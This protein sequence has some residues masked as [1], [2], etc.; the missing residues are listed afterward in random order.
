MRS[1]AAFGGSIVTTIAFYAD[2]GYA[3]LSV[4]HKPT[5]RIRGR[6]LS[7]GGPV[8]ARHQD[9]GWYIG[10]QPITRITCQGAFGLEIEAGGSVL[11]FASLTELC[12][13]GDIV[14]SFDGPLARFCPHENTWVKPGETMASLPLAA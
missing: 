2:G 13:V 10:T 9:G 3:E 7:A 4:E 8:L 11:Q 14:V 1:A 6:E 12:L 5:L